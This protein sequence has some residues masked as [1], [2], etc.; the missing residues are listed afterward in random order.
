MSK[1][2]VNFK[3]KEKIRNSTGH[4]QV[5]A[6]SYKK[7]GVTYPCYMVRGWKV[8]GKWQRKQFQDKQEAEDFAN[9]ININLK[10]AGHHRQ[11]LLTSL[12]EA[13]IEHAEKA[14]DDL[15]EAYS[16]DEAIS[17]FLKH[18][19][20]PEFTIDL[21]AGLKIYLEEKDRDG[22]RLTT[23][24]KTRA[25]LTRF[26][27]FTNNPQV[28]SV[29][30]EETIK[31]LKS[32]RAQNGISPAKK[33]T[34]NNHRNELAAFFI[35]AGKK[36]LSTNRPWTF[37]NPTEHVKAHSN[38][39]LAE[40]RPDIATTAPEIVRD[41]FTYLMS[42]KGGRLVKWFALAYFAG[43]R[44]STDQGELAK[45]SE[46]EKE[47]I[48]LSTGRIMITAEM[49]KTK[50]SRPIRISD[51]LKVWLQAYE[52]F[53]IMPVNF[54]N[55]YRQVRKKFSL[56]S[57]ET[58]HSFISYHIALHRSIGDTAQEAGNS[59][60]MIKKHYLDHRPQEQGRDF[61]SIVPDIENQRA[62]INPDVCN[63]LPDRLRAI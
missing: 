30:E 28:H 18:H 1:K 38:Q 49:A 4:A 56:Q 32:L 2:R 55:D 27:S 47:L 29:T 20:P 40:Q 19:R 22:V 44:P 14:F 25:I 46:R 41:L 24:K 5:Y 35:W 21:L 37:H 54:K 31:Y 13:Q 59:E 48:N 10:N 23:I 50:D 34:W 63:E 53:P 15:G 51:N 3:K 62:V 58:R 39:R 11:L 61:F 60:R 26:A 16:L 52:E 42:Y 45:L 17:F 43:I 8:D 7:R 33:K 36:D 9:S 57:D 6:T 12:N